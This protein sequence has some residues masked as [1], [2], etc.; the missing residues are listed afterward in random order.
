MAP[1]Q[2]PDEDTD[3]D[4]E[5]RL[6]NPILAPLPIRP[7][8]IRQRNSSTYHPFLQRP[9]FGALLFS[10]ETSDAR[11][12]CASERTFLSWLRLAV[13]L[14]VVGVAL[15]VSFHLK[16]KPS[17]LEL[18]V[19]LPLGVVFWVLSLVCLGA[20]VSNY[21][22]TLTMYGQR[23]ALVQTGWKTQAVSLGANGAGARSEA[24]V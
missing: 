21:I 19:A 9:F 13:Y 7:V 14:A 16:N 12:H 11:D 20:G 5:P 22:V 1:P 8:T 4:I 6:F 23:R 15:V 18:K 2:C 17:E 10:N 24:N 3:T